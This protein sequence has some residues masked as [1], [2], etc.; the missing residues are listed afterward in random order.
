MEHKGYYHKG[1]YYRSFKSFQ[2]IEGAKILFLLILALCA[3]ASPFVVTGRLQR[4]VE[5]I[6]FFLITA[7][8]SQAPDINEKSAYV[9]E[10]E[11]DARDAGIPPT[12]F[13]RQIA[14]ESGFNPYAVS[15]T[16]AVGIAQFEPDT[17]A[18]LGIDP[19]DVHSAL[20]GAAFLMARYNQQY[21]DYAKALA[22][23]N[24]GTGTLTYCLSH[25]GPAWLTCEPAETRNYIATIM[26]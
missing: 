25:F 5:K 16:G 17:A 1:K 4:E 19:Y 3:V 13:V 21:G 2:V 23:Y 20:R 6:H 24:G 8:F 7:H 14:M 10:A 18:G 26:S 11:Q 9:A 22:A 15:D 12:L